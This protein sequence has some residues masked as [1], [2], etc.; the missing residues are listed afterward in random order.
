MAEIV[1]IGAGLTGLSAAYHLEKQGFTDYKLFEKEAEV[2]GLCRSVYQDGFTFDYTGHLLHINDA[3]FKEFISTVAGFENFNTI[4][5]KSFIYSQDTYTHYPF[6]VNLHGL[7]ARTITECIEG[8]INRPRTKK[9]PLDFKKWVLTSF[10]KGIAEH[11]FY[12]YQEKIF[13]YP[14][15]KLSASWTGR[16]VPKTSLT[17]MIQ[18]AIQPPQEQ[19]IGYNAQFFYPKQE[20]IFFWIKRLYQQLQQPVYTNH[21]VTSIN[22]NEKKVIFADGSSE[23]YKTLINTMPLNIFLK[24]LTGH[25]AQPLKNASKKLLCNSVVNFNLGIE[26][27]N[28]SDKH[29][30]YYPEK[31]YPFYRI[32]FSNNFAQS[33][34]P[35][36]CSSLYGEFSHLQKPQHEVEELL[37]CALQQTKK[38][39]HI[40]D[41]EIVTEKIITIPHAYVIFDRWRDNNLPK[42]LTRLAQENIHSIG[43]YGAWKYSSMQEG[44]LE[45]KAISETLLPS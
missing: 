16:F 43:R 1:I 32:G 8:F 35:A 2:G 27:E 11:F 34:A 45:G 17:E 42:L 22:L 21:T 12:P 29:W 26:R 10:G 37:A 36:G 15:D 13:S 20:G 25:S 31:Q 5:R 40:A 23:H 33:M 24:L 44:L 7:P 28:F 19:Q 18:G 14:V 30:I 9:L 4:H 3:Y 6:Q 39:L 38:I 41:S